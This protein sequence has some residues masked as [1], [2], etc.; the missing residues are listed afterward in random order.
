MQ[1]TIRFICL[2]MPVYIEGH[3]AAACCPFSHLKHLTLCSKVQEHPAYT[4]FCFLGATPILWR[5]CRNSAEGAAP[6]VNLSMTQMS[7]PWISSKEKI[8]LSVFH[9]SPLEP[10]TFYSVTSL[11]FALWRQK[12]GLLFPL[13]VFTA[14]LAD[15]CCVSTPIWTCTFSIQWLCTALTSPFFKYCERLSTA[16]GY[17]KYLTFKC[18]RW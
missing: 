1:G 6:W 17:W 8:F 12:C 13:Q 4:V 2:F 16:V 18:G 15:Q 5:G 10:S 14:F 3:W 7:S 11:S 9:I